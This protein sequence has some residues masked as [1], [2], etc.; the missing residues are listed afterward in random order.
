M[1]CFCELVGE[2]TMQLHVLPTDMLE[3]PL[4]EVYGPDV[5]LLGR[6]DLFFVAALQALQ[7]R[8]FFILL[9]QLL[10]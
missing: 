5:L 9:R 2:M 7:P 4:Q 8:H 6:H 1:W 3:T 10:V